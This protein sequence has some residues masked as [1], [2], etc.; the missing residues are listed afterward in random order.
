MPKAKAGAET[1]RLDLVRYE[2]RRSG[3]VKIKLERF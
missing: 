3:G 1:Y 2:L